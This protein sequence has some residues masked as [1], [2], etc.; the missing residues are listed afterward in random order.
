MQINFI[1]EIKKQTWN[2]FLIANNGSF[3]Q[4]FEWGNFQEQSS[5]KVWRVE[6]EGN[7]E[8][9]L[10]A[11]IIKER[12]SG[13][14]SFYIPYGPVFNQNV[15]SK[16][17]QEAFSLLLKNIRQ[18]A[19]KEKT[20]FLRIEPI[21]VLPKID[22]FHF[23][24][25][26]KR[27]QPQRTLV[28]DL[29]KSEKELFDVIKTKT[30]YNIKLAQRKGVTIK[31][32]DD[33]SPVFYD[34]VKGTG[35]RQQFSSF[36][37]EHYMKFF[38]IKSK[39]FQVKM[40]LAEY[41]GKVIVASVVVFFGNKAISLHTGSDYQYRTVKGADLLRWRV[42]LYAKERGYKQYDFWGIDDKKFPGVTSFKKGF[43][44]REVEYPLGVDV[45]FNN[46]GYNVYRIIRAVKQLF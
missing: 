2:E 14:N 46:T 40:F 32:L 25:P 21:V 36:P 29:D 22:K 15:S 44:G 23:E 39:D 12:I 26:F 37:Q 45:I 13:F 24:N 35:Q 38:Q 5:L 20:W 27:N 17:K 7:N 9:I 31:I 8:K 4:S 1:D 28:L 33:Y 30:K 34:L 11:Q 41:Q 16:E 6:I 43:Q 10:V 42:I 3:L 19:Q 18:L